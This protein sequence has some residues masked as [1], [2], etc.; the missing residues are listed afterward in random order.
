[1]PKMLSA[2]MSDDSAIVAA[3]DRSQ[4][5]IHFDLAGN[6]LFANANF[7]AAVGYELAEIV[8]RHHRMF[9]DAAEAESA[10]YREFW[11]RLA[12]GE[13]DQRQYKRFAKG[14]REI[15]IEASY[16]PLF[17]RGKPYK[18]VK[19]ATD[20]T[21]ARQRAA[22]DAGK[23]EAI[24]KSQA[25]IEFTPQGE[26]LTANDNF[27]KTL[28]YELTEIQGRHHRMFCDPAYVG[29]EE[30][31]QFWP[32]LARGEFIANEFVRYGKGG[33]E[34]WIQ[35][36]YNPIVDLDGKVVKVVKFATDVSERMSAV[37]ALGG[38]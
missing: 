37:V 8:G 1:M 30:Y 19:F 34:V 33:K 4:A 38:G 11:A 13:Y 21:A 18:V 12:R 5:V 14:G 35:A 6:I 10:E 16:N 26:I 20:I 24:S 29:S 32:R 22:E 2:L 31:R 36:A 27:C 3:I 28:G 7:C 17:R 9:V 23:L 25:V 15:W